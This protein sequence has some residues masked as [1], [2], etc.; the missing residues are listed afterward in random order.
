MPTTRR[1]FLAQSLGAAA[2]VALARPQRALAVEQSRILVNHVGFTPTGSKFCLV[3]PAE[4]GPFSLVNTTSGKTAFKGDVQILKGDHGTYAVGDFSTECPAGV[5]RIVVG[6]AESETFTLHPQIYTPAIGKCIAYF[7][8]QRCGN[9]QTGHHAPCHTDDGRRQDNGKQHD[10]S[11]G[12]HD[13]C[14]LRKWVNATVYGVIGLSRAL[15]AL[16]KDHPERERVVDEMKWGNHYFRKMQEPDGYVMDHCGGDQGNN[17]TDNVAGSRD[18]RVI[19]VEPAELPAQ[20]HFI[21]AQAALVRYT[22]DSD[23]EYARGCEQAARRCLEWCTKKRQPRAATSLA[24][25]MIACA[26][27]HRATGDA[28]LADQAAEYARLLLSLQITDK[29]ADNSPRGFFLINPDKPDPSREIMHGNLPLLALCEVLEEFAGHA[30]AETWRRALE[31]HIEYLHMMSSR[32]AFATIPFGLYVGKDPGG[33]R[34]IGRYWYRWFMQNHHEQNASDWWVGINAHLA[35]N[36]VGL[37]KAGRLLRDQRLAVLAQRQL[38]WV[39]GVN[40]FDAS[41]ISEVGR[42]QP[43]LYKTGQFKPPTP[44][45]PGGVM[46]GLG[47]TPQDEPWLGAGSWNTCEYW[48]PMVAYTMWLMS[49]LQK[50]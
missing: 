44:M 21:A 50:P 2:A 18:D 1:R 10:V 25:G 23:A 29:D 24:A 41:T 47:G 4:A 46:N 6:G 5:F 16:G 31:V 35:S 36:G 26:Q 19:H 20:F 48:T 9:S 14:D 30:D 3:S 8:K 22:R 15:D 40:P 45:I 12:W 27:L 11:G 17:Y 33:N 49:E 7:A 13:A 34:R 32:S 39:L 37:I 38:D 43:R 42:N 28:T